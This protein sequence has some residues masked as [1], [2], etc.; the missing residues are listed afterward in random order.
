MG[1]NMRRAFNSHTTVK[2]KISYRLDGAWDAKNNWV[3]GG[4]TFPAPF[5]V[6]PTPSGNRDDAAYGDTLQA[7]P[8]LERIP[9]HMK[10]VS[11]TDMPV[12]CIVEIYDRAYKITKRGNY[13]GFGFYSSV[14][15]LI[16]IT[17][18]TDDN[19]TY[20]YSEDGKNLITETYQYIVGEPA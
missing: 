10:F 4:L 1:M 2:G 13:K 7:R 3:K 9:S 18:E 5:R 16:S 20:T 19:I 14:G 8:E 11:R 15:A 12:N 17:Q 6:T